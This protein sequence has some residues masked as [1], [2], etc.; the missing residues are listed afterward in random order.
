[1]IMVLKQ[2]K[3]FSKESLVQLEMV[4]RKMA[5][6]MAQPLTPVKMEKWKMKDGTMAEKSRK[7]IQLST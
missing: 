4:Q 6:G 2:A 3:Q 5:S 7:Y 1:M